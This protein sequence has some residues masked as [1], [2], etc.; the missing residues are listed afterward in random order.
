MDKKPYQ[1][2]MIEV[3]RFTGSMVIPMGGGNVFFP[4]EDTPAVEK[5]EG[6]KTDLPV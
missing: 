1:A 3:I 2:P 6:Q 5:E 4:D